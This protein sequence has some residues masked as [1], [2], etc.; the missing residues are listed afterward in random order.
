MKLKIHQ[1]KN[2]L[3]CDIDCKNMSD[4]IGF[5]YSVPHPPP[6]QSIF[7]GPRKCSKKVA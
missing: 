6:P 4:K 5:S 7:S 2:I 3:K 1:M